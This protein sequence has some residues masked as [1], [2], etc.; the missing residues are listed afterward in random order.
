MKGT[1]IYTVFKQKVAIITLQSN[2]KITKKI[3]FLLVN[4]I[5]C[6]IDFIRYDYIIFFV[7]LSFDC[8]VIMAIFA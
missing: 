8:N 2:D 1:E 6:D 3:T 7:I 5:Y 4:L